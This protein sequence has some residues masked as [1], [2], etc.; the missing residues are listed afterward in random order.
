[1]TQAT[2]TAETVHAA[3]CG[4][5]DIP[6]TSGVEQIFAAGYRDEATARY[7]SQVTPIYAVLSR[8]LAQLSGVLLL[9]LTVPAGRKAG[10]LDLDHAVFTVAADQLTEARERLRALHAPAAA[11][12]HHA[13]LSDCAQHLHHAMQGMDR[14]PTSLGALRDAAQR[15]IIRALHSAQRLLIATAEPDAR[16]TPVD[17]SN[18]CC[19]CGAIHTRNPVQP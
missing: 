11:A 4:I 7:L 16:I 13:A 1:M 10:A 19:S 8:V 14:L 15:D 9:A 12:R 2:R 3:D 18:A 5:W 17:F 6:E